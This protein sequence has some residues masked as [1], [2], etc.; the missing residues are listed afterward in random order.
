MKKSNDKLG[1]AL[2]GLGSYSTNQLAPAFAHSKNCKLAGIV[3]GTPVKASMWKRKYE[4]SEGGIYSYENFDTIINNSDI[5]IVYV[6]TPNSMH[7]DFVCRAAEAGKHVICEKPLGINVNDCKEMIAVCRSNGVKLSVGYRLCYDPYINHLKEIVQNSVGNIEITG[8]LG[9]K[10]EDKSNWRLSKEVSGGGALIDI[11]IYGIY[12]SC[13]VLGLTPEKV[14]AIKSSKPSSLF[15]EV[16]ESISFELHFGDSKVSFYCTYS[17]NTNWLRLIT[18]SEDLLV[19]NAFSPSGQLMNSLGSV[20]FESVNQAALHMDDFANS[21]L[22][23]C[24]VK[25]SGEDALRDAIILNALYRAAL[26]EE[27]IEINYN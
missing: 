26:T 16:E 10:M 20:W 9:F 11:G 4:L 23:N 1:V 25:V 12:T 19:E 7:R 8:S 22:N 18:S 3:T 14:T 27:M 2:L 13:Y 21:I 15:E 24:K 17:T 5:D 6:T